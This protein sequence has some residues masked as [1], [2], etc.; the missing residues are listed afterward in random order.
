VKEE[1]RMRR[2]IAALAAGFTV[3]LTLVSGAAVAAA[4]AQNASQTSAADDGAYWGAVY[5]LAQTFTPTVTGN[6]DQVSI[7]IAID[8][9]P[10]ADV[11]PAALPQVRVAIFV[12]SG[13]LPTGSALTE[14]TFTAT[15]G[16]ATWHDVPLSVPVAVTK[17]VVYALLIS[18]TAG[19][20]I[21]WPGVC[22]SNPY[23]GGQALIVDTRTANPWMDLP[24]WAAANQGSSAVCQ[25]DFAF[26]TFITGGATPPPTS[27]S[28][29]P[30]APADGQSAALLLLV[31]LAAAGAF[32][33]AR[34]AAPIKP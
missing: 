16:A 9:P 25:N 21:D 22:G 6:L 32:V 18:G 11:V 17:N 24:S 1:K 20:F 31:G 28:G 2:R 15:T 12:T 23:A 8:I 7:D 13:G 29:R 3:I 5:G 26:K 33:A 34:R 19:V 10:L 14:E 4:G 30:A 27:A